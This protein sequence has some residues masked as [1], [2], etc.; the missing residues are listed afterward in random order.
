MF[1]RHMMLEMW[2]VVKVDVYKKE[3][4]IVEHLPFPTTAEETVSEII[5][6]A[7]FQTGE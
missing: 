6:T 7:N 2:T 4:L 3:A 1:V 5:E